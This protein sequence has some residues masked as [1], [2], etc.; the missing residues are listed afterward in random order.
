MTGQQKKEVLRDFWA[1]TA[2]KSRE[3]IDEIPYWIDWYSTTDEGSGLNKSE[4]EAVLKEAL[5]PRLSFLQIANQ[6]D[7]LK[8]EFDRYFN[9]GRPYQDKHSL[10]SQLH[11]S[12]EQYGFRIDSPSFDPTLQPED[13]QLS[14]S[15]S[16]NGRD[17]RFHKTKHQINFQWS[18]PGATFKAIVIIDIPLKVANIA[19]RLVR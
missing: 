2:G 5:D 12:V 11:R 19:F 3:W 14:S 7:R 18:K 4:I 13:G 17:G 1:W 10:F 8:Q 16:Q 15:I 6:I 9:S